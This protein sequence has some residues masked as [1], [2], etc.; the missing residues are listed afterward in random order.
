MTSA[1]L[2]QMPSVD[3]PDL[4]RLNAVSAA[5]DEVRGRLILDGV[6]R[7]DVIGLE[8]LVPGMMRG[9]HPNSFTI[10]S[11]STKLSVALE[12]INLKKYAVVG[13][14]VSIAIGVIIK[15]FYWLKEMW[16]TFKQRQLSEAAIKEAERQLQA[17]QEYLQKQVHDVPVENDI[18]AE[19]VRLVT[20]YGVGDYSMFIF[21]Y[22]AN[23]I[24]RKALTYKE[25]E[26]IAKEIHRITNVHGKTADDITRYVLLFGLAQS[27]ANILTPICGLTLK[28]IHPKESAY[29]SNMQYSVAIVYDEILELMEWIE[30]AYRAV[31]DQRNITHYIQNIGMWMRNFCN[32][33]SKDGVIPP[34]GVFKVNFSIEERLIE[35]KGEMKRVQ[36]PLNQ[37]VV[38]WPKLLE[39]LNWFQERRAI[40]YGLY[41]HHDDANHTPFDKEGIALLEELSHEHNREELAIFLRKMKTLDMSSRYVQL[42]K[43]LDRIEKEHAEFLSEGRSER[44]DRVSTPDG[45][46]YNLKHISVAEVID[47]AIAFIRSM[48]SAL[49]QIEELNL[50]IA[51]SAERAE[52]LYTNAARDSLAFVKA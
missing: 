46:G 38:F 21:S 40:R 27:K 51:T 20:T 50:G 23:E 1:L 36:M 14:A 18:G 32:K 13:A 44:F 9:A 41:T 2:S 24:H 33:F 35:E 52:R 30:G 15:L 34:Q 5:L 3:H 12:A 10:N 31:K 42:I 28:S 11:S 45:I 22:L 19:A 39:I 43:V 7:Q 26:T 8:S 29:M 48:T 4:Y 16:V 17:T 6:C 49:R 37:Q 47:N 25:A